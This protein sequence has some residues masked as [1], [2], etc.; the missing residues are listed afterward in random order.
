M[1]QEY[2]R[3]LARASEARESHHSNEMQAVISKAEA[4]AKADQNQLRSLQAALLTYR[5]IG[6]IR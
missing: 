1:R 3:E 2:E 5:V 6:S 4:Q